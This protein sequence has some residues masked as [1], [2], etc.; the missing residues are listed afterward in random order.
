VSHGDAWG[1]F[2]GRTLI[3]DRQL[4]AWRQARFA[5]TTGG[6]PVTM[7]RARL[8]WSIDP[9]APHPPETN[10]GGGGG[11]HRR[12]APTHGFIRTEQSMTD[13]AKAYRYSLRDVRG[14]LGAQ[15][16]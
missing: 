3:V 15:P 8:G 4:A 7:P 5:A 6:S 9:A 10:A 16:S 2:H 14:A 1:T 12:A 11:S 13:D